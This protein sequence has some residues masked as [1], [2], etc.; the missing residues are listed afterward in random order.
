[1]K[2]VFFAA[3]L[4]FTTF[5]A[6]QAETNIQ[7][8]VQ[9]LGDCASEEACRSYCDNSANI[10]RC[11]TFAEKNSMMSSEEVAEARK[12]AAIGSGPG[13]C[14][15]KDS[16]E[17]Y[18]DNA[19]NIRECISFAEKNGFM[20]GDELKEAKQIIR[21]L[22][23]GASLPG[24]CTNERSCDSYCSDE[25]NIL[26]CVTFAEA[27]GFISAEEASMAR[28]TGGKGPGG[29]R[30]RECEAF[31][32]NPDN[33]EVCYNFALE[34]GLMDP[35][36][37]KGSRDFMDSLRNAPPEVK[38]CIESELGDTSRVFPGPRTGAKLRDCYEQFG[39]P[40]QDEGMMRTGPGGCSS[41]EECDA[42]C[43]ANPLECRP[44][45]GSEMEQQ[46]HENYTEYNSSQQQMEQVQYQ[47]GQRT[48][49]EQVEQIQTEQIREV[50]QGD[51]TSLIEQ[52]MANVMT[53]FS[54]LIIR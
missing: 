11:L 22:D 8:P 32:S 40:P 51:E 45:G 52:F 4:T 21:A 23:S 31:C 54:Q 6:V 10:E 50:E 38:A 20:S 26:E 15:S 39:R 47:E 1:M 48:Q 34:H 49:T 28:K 9:E 30:G 53:A 29:C 18:C 5:A 16:C 44:E 41:R 14:T 42:Y 37:E 43:L 7:F 17:S 33:G 36:M 25:A 2:K 46:Y 19:A 13:G 24:G 35:E 27:A 12:F 3:I